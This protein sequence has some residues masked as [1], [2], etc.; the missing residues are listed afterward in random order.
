MSL[1][2]TFEKIIL[3][4]SYPSRVDDVLMDYRLGYVDYETQQRVTNYEAVV[5]LAEALE[6]AVNENSRDTNE[7]QGPKV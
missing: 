1:S 3:G 4:H 5:R 7:S 6:G 2:K